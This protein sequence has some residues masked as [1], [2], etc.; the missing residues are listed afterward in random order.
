MHRAMNKRSRDP[1]QAEI[2]KMKQGE[3][4]IRVAKGVLRT[5]T[6]LKPA[7]VP[8]VCVYVMDVIAWIE[9]CNVAGRWYPLAE[10]LFHVWDE[11]YGS[12]YLTSKGADTSVHGFF[13]NTISRS[14]SPTQTT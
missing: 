3:V 1:M 10:C 2:R 8:D 9:R 4:N 14:A 13:G 7:S 5:C 6:M 12:S 11:A